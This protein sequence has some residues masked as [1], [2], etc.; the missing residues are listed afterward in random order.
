MTAWQCRCGWEG[1]NPSFTDASEL[2]PTADGAMVMD[3]THIPICPRCFGPVVTVREAQARELRQVLV[4]I[5][6]MAS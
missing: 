5:A 1:F 2:K 6:R 3:R 4:G